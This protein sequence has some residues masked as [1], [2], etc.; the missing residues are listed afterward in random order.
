MDLWRA[1]LLTEQLTI[2]KAQRRKSEVPRMD[3]MWRTDAPGRHRL[4]YRRWPDSKLNTQPILSSLII[5]INWS[6]YITHLLPRH[7]KTR[8]TEC[9]MRLTSDTHGQKNR[10]KHRK[11]WLQEQVNVEYARHKGQIWMQKQNNK[12]IKVSSIK[13]HQFP[14][15]MS[16]EDWTSGHHPHIPPPEKKIAVQ[17][18]KFFTGH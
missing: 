17:F 2:F 8:L 13:L 18:W 12:R 7:A 15:V 16:I 10:N 5:A 1:S 11:P 6:F 14:S 3:G 4:P 9:R